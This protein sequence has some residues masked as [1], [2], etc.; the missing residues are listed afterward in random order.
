MK[1][2]T[3]LFLIMLSTR[4]TVAQ[5]TT[6]N[7]DDSK[8]D[9][10]LAAQLDSIYKLDQSVRNNYLK[11]KEVK[12]APQVADSL[13]KV[14]LKTDQ[15]NLAAVNAII[16]KHGWLGPQKVGFDGSNGLFLVIQHADLKTQQHYLP[17]IREA[18]KKGELL[19]SHL[20]ILEDRINMRQGKK[21]LYGSQGFTDYETGKKYI[22]PVTDVD[23]L[24]NRRKAM[25][26]PPMKQYETDWN[27]EEYKKQLPEIERVVKKQFRAE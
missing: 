20:A 17:I 3:L 13:L 4:V 18:E 8:I 9:H 27:V 1:N 6:F 5:V 25:G 21:Q 16:D 24:D 15:E 23:N 14:M 2:L 22:Y 11:A 12:A 7:I 19:S 10:A 26:M